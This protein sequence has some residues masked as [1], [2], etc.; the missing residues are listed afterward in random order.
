MIELR[1]CESDEDLEAWRHVRIAVVPYELTPSLD[2]LRRAASPERQMLLAYRDGA[3]AGS[4][5]GGRGDTGGGFAVP[6]VLPEHR[7]RGVGTALLRMIADH[8]EALGLRE[9]GVKADDEGAL[10]FA[11]R[12]GFDEVGREI[13]QVREV[14][15]DEPWP[16]PPDGVVLVSLAERPELLRRLYEELAL[17]A[18]EDMPTPGT[19]EITAERWEADWVTWPEATFAALAGDEVVGMAGLIRDPDQPA[20]AENALTAVR[21][22]FRGRG[23]ARALK[24]T[25]IAW[26]SG[27]GLREIYTWTQ[28]GNENMR[29][30]NEKLGYV[31]RTVSISLRRP[32]PLST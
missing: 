12:F 27:R 7:R 24:E 16:A 23:L 1:P 10:A 13:E 2:D 32:L 11:T 6:R 5:L 14:G 9:I 4:G 15:P 21:R 17:Q 18:F 29:T 20:R 19:I 26:A 8:V 25:T 31:T 22:D 30:V 28:A 3:L